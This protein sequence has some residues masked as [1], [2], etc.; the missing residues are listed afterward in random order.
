MTAFAVVRPS[1]DEDVDTSHVGELDQFHSDPSAW[2][3]G[4]GRK[5]MAAVIETLRTW[6]HRGDPLDLEGPSPAT[7]EVAGWTLDGATRDKPPCS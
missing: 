2:G 7:Y 5:L 3:E 1:R 6:L 4:V